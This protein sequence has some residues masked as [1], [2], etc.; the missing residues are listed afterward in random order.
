MTHVAGIG[1]IYGQPADQLPELE[2]IQSAIQTLSTPVP[3]NQVK[4]GGHYV[5]KFNGDGKLYRCEVLSFLALLT[6]YY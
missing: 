2:Q 4:V 5:T 1:F 3:K 6:H